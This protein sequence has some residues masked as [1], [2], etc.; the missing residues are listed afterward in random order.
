MAPG[1]WNELS[2]TIIA[3]QIV[4][5]SERGKGEFLLPRGKTELCK[6]H[7]FNFKYTILV[8]INCF[9]EENC[10]EEEVSVLIALLGKLK[11]VRN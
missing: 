9:S 5:H 3:C 4:G 11:N 6:T 8:D 7:I 10:S 1:E 2:K